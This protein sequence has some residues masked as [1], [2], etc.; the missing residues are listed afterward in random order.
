MVFCFS[1]WVDMVTNGLVLAEWRS[2]TDQGL[3]HRAWWILGVVFC[4]LPTAAVTAEAA[5]YACAGH[6]FQM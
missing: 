3:L 4:V 6:R 1:P 5:Y 2:F